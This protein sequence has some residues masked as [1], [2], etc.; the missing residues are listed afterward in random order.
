MRQPGLLKVFILSLI[1]FIFPT[2]AFAQQTT[3]PQTSNQETAENQIPVIIKHLPDW[4]KARANA[5]Y[6]SNSNDLRKNLGERP[7][8]NL[9]TFE[10]GTEAVT[11]H[12]D[13]GKLL[14]VEYSTPQFSIDADNRIKQFFTENP[15]NPAIY[16]R[17]VGNYEVFV[18]DAASESAANELIDQ[19]K[20]EKVVQ[21]LGQ[22]PYLYQKA[23]RAYLQTTGDMFITTIFSIFL[24]LTLA[25][26]TGAAIGLFVFYFR[27]HKRASMTAFSDAGGMIRLNLDELTPEISADKLLKE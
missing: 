22:D 5:V 6:I 15:P 26:F 12:Y 3:S 4:E 7:V 21:W 1:I 27:K 14:I 25:V 18:F 23:E 8:F 11:A 16:F 10:G 17:R 20:Y 2:G 9:I 19:V 24:G 13:A